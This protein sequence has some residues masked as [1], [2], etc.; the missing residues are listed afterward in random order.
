MKKVSVEEEGGDSSEQ[1]GEEEEGEE[2][3]EE[4]E[5]SFKER[6]SEIVKECTHR[7]SR[8]L[9]PELSEQALA[10]AATARARAVIHCQRAVLLLP[11]GGYEAVRQAKGAMAADPTYERGFVL[12]GLAREGEGMR[13][14]ALEMYRLAPHSAIAAERIAALEAHRGVTGVA[15]GTVDARRLQ[16]FGKDF[17]DVCKY[18]VATRR[19]E[20]RWAEF[21]G[22][23]YGQHRED[24][25]SVIG[26]VARLCF[27]CL[28][29]WPVATCLSVMMTTRTGKSA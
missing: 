29:K 26:D 5:E 3:E 25:R 13:K 17:R 1:Q 8:P 12:C 4:E 2:E 24:E 23:E 28:P 10:S 21:G 22:W 19:L 11:L 16:P 20:E 7:I 15:A 9:P 18:L 14:H 6:M 27:A